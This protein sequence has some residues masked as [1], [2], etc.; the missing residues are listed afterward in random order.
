[1]KLTSFNSIVVK[2]GS[3]RILL[4]GEYSFYRWGPLLLFNLS[5]VIAQNWHFAESNLFRS[6]LAAL[7]RPIA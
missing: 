2:L 5:K 6:T 7:T 3:L 4:P 1:L